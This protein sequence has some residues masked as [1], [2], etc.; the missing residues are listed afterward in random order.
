MPYTL[1]PDSKPGF[2]T[3]TRDDGKS[4][5]FTSTL[6]TL[7]D[8][9]VIVRVPTAYGVGWTIVGEADTF[10]PETVLQGLSEGS[11]TVPQEAWQ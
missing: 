7:E 10:S 1:S 2:P 5:V 11:F 3:V 8:L 4:A 9:Y 6:R